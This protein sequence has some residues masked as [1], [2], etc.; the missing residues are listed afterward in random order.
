MEDKNQE[1]TNEQEDIIDHSLE[2]MEVLYK[3]R[4]SCMPGLSNVTITEIPSK[5]EEE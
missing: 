1:F 5:K 2:Q 3:S 4:C